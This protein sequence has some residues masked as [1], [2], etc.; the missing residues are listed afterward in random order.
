MSRTKKGKKQCGYDYW[1]RRPYSGRG[2]GPDVKD[3]CHRSERMQG[4]EQILK[5]L[6]EQEA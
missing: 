2:F 5:E 1:S 6:K 4:K 3:A